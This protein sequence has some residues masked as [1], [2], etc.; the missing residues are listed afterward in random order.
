[1]TGPY[2]MPYRG[3]FEMPLPPAELW[4]RLEWFDRYPDW[5]GWLREF[6]ADGEGLTAGT[7]LRGTVHPPVPYAMRVRVT[8]VE[9]RPHTYIA[10]D[11]DGD[12]RGPAELWLDEQGGEGCRVT[13]AWQVEMLQRRMRLATRVAR[14]MLRWGHDR[15]VESTVRGFRR[16]LGG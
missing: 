1:M 8:F 9:C 13:V 4:R 5:W 12:L 16:R 6:R 7:V 14:P 10:A 15:V 3:T 11:V 2:D